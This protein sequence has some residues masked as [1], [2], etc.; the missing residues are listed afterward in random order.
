[1]T[2]VFWGNLMYEEIYLALLIPLFMIPSRKLK[3]SLRKITLITGAATTAMTLLLMAGCKPGSSR[4][5]PMEKNSGAHQSD[6]L[7]LIGYRPKQTPLQFTTAKNT[8]LRISLTDSLHWEPKAQ[9]LETDICVFLDPT[10]QFQQVTGFGG[11]ITDASAETLARLPEN[12]QDSL[13]TA[14]YDPVKGIGYN[15][16]RTN[17]GSCDFSSA[18]YMYVAENDTTLSTFSVAHDE[19]FKIPL[20]KRAM[21]MAGKDFSL[22]ASPWTPPAWMKDNHDILHGG[23][24]LKRYYGLW[25]DYLVKFIQAY[26][27]QGIDLWG[28]S[29]QNEPMANQSWESCIYTAEEER[30][31]IK[32]ALGP[33]LHKNDLQ[34]VKLIAWDHNRDLLPQRASVLL[35]D[36]ETAKYIW[37]LGFHWYET[38]SGTK[39]LYD[40]VQKVQE[41]YP[42]THL[43]FTEGCQEKFDYRKLDDWTLGEKYADNIL[44]DLNHGITAY[45]DWNILLDQTGGPNHVGNFCF[46]PV[47]ANIEK[48][49][50]HFTNAFW[51]I[52]QFSKFIHKGARRISSASNRS[53]LQVSAFINPDGTLAAVVLN[54]TDKDIAFHIWLNGQWAAST[55]RA[56]SLNTILL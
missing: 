49:E 55:A 29:V 20:I 39:P 32:T 45:C 25:A 37:G 11:A 19:K 51:Y 28:I 23:H 1:M 9:P 34:H 30:D 16:G 43:L 41:A 12:L 31:F 2:G 40:N 47:I 44:H 4:Q 24:L 21:N 15:F 22:F 56:H 7:A 14:Y 33:A 35:N 6:S 13:I 36:P 52:G 38:W 26:H 27:K 10:R 50:L 5:K 48:K 17:I 3:Y 46:A 18:S 42:N 53:D 8:M 54:Q